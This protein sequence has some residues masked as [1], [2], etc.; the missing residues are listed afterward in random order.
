MPMQRLSKAVGW[1]AFKRT[2]SDVLIYLSLSRPK[3][4]VTSQ[5]TSCYF[6]EVRT[7]KAVYEKYIKGLFQASASATLPA[8]KRKRRKELEETPTALLTWDAVR[9]SLELVNGSADAC[10]PL[11]SVVGAV[12][13]LCNLAERIAACDE[14]AEMLAWRSVAIIDTIYNSIDPNDAIPTHFL[15]GFLQFEQLVNEIRTAMEAITKKKRFLRVLHLRRSESELDKFTKRLDSAAEVFM[16]RSVT[17][18]TM[19][20]A[21]IEDKVDNVAAVAS[22][23]Q[24]SNV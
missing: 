13:A 7:A 14:N 4:S 5:S 22:T 12:V 6:L 23:I 11:K 9:T 3:S 24:N 17:V 10:P 19:S 16:I 21:R 20:V 18:Q 1:P 2:R 8:S 15:D